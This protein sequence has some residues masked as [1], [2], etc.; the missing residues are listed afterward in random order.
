MMLYSNDLRN[1][2]SRVLAS[3]VLA[4]L[5]A[6]LHKTLIL[7]K[8]NFFEVKIEKFSYDLTEVKNSIKIFLDKFPLFLQSK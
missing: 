2:V 1:I 3:A 7:R 6:G 8:K 5:F 4:S